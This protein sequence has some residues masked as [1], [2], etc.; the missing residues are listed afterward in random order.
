[1]WKP[2]QTIDKNQ[3]RTIQIEQNILK[4][5]TWG[6]SYKSKS[7]E[8]T[9]LAFKSQ[10]LA[11]NFKKRIQEFKNNRRY[12]NDHPY[13]RQV[14]IE[15]NPVFVKK[16]LQKVCGTTWGVVRE[17]QQIVDRVGFFFEDFPLQFPPLLTNQCSDS[18]SHSK[19]I[20]SNM[21][22]IETRQLCKDDASV[23]ESVISNH[24]STS[25]KELP[26][27]DSIPS[28]TNS[29][30]FTLNPRNG[31]KI[32][33]DLELTPLHAISSE[34]N[35]YLHESNDSEENAVKEQRFPFQPRQGVENILFL[36]QNSEEVECNEINVHNNA[37]L[38]IGEC[39]NNF[40]ALRSTTSVNNN[41]ITEQD[42]ASISLCMQQVNLSES[43]DFGYHEV[44]ESSFGCGIDENP[45]RGSC[46]INQT[47]INSDISQFSRY[48]DES[49]SNDTID[50]NKR[51]S[52][53]SIEKQEMKFMHTL[54]NQ[55]G[56]KLLLFRSPPPTK[57]EL[58]ESMKANQINKTRSI[59]IHYSKE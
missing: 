37:M 19:T 5:T 42:K 50:E 14:N 18:T 17:K 2:T 57:E 36:S 21:D 11:S 12:A 4:E 39:T 7:G 33:F 38:S 29:S 24:H 54:W 3:T 13:F 22:T 26:I 40:S 55:K 25:S 44:L 43:K 47:V 27:L 49:R 48:K 52:L 1:M 59:P 30:N 58:Q 16:K 9:S 28:D 34:K 23:I 31:F 46:N 8:E 6:Q 10:D 15:L 45:I 41:Q 20:E 32:D 56:M 53:P 35:S 51:F